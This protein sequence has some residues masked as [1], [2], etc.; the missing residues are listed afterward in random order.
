M[1]FDQSLVDKNY[2]ILCYLRDYDL[3]DF[4][5]K[6]SHFLTV[7]DERVRFAAVEA[8]LEQDHNDV[9]GLVE[10]FLSDTSVENIRIKNSVIDAFVRKDWSVKDLTPFSDGKISERVLVT[11]KGKVQALPPL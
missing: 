6:L 3:A 5:P 1:R 8:L 4:S 9:P 2:D 10:R 7:P 11:K